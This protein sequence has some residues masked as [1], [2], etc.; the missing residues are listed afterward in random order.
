MK[1]T[2]IVQ[3]TSMLFLM[4]IAKLVFPFFTLPYLTR[5]LSVEGY[6]T[7][8]YVRA[9][10]Q[11]MQLLVDFGF[12]L[13]ATKMIVNSIEDMKTVGHIVSNTI[14]AKLLLSVIGFVVLVVVSLAIPLLRENLLYAYLS[15]IV[16]VLSSFLMDFLFRGLEQMQ[17]ITIRFVVMKGIST[18]LTFIMVH[19]D[20]DLLWIPVLDILSSFV[21]I[22]WVW[23]R[24]RVYGVVLCRPKLHE[25]VTYIRESFEY[26]LSSIAST[27]FGALNTLLIGICLSAEEVALWT[28]ALQICSAV[29]AMY[30]PIID[31]IYPEMVKTRSRAMLIK[32][33]MLFMPVVLVGCVVLYTLSEFA[34]WIVAGAKYLNAALVLRMLI[35]MLFISFPALLFGWPALGAIGKVKETS[36][37]T[38]V[39][40]CFQ[41]IG[42]VVLVIMNDISLLR[43]AFLR[44][45]AEFVLFAMRFG[46][47]LKHKAS[48][49]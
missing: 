42:L 27:A 9:V 47:C 3:N 33:S 22:V 29:Q 1:K 16:V 14:L 7:V 49:S 24:I 5:V 46:L 20:A 28:V 44:C 2:K 43:I 34:I 18:A 10:I 11:Y 36:R 39:A 40:A 21:A 25:A 31:G 23:K 48:F 38:I 30:S 13:S 8:S 41:C 4:S 6:A 17:E 32:V 19:S 35:P 37:T 12:I 15:F 45:I 26:F